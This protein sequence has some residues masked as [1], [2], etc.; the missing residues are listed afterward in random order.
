[1]LLMWLLQLRLW[2]DLQCII[3]SSNSCC[4]MWLLQLR[5]WLDLQCIILSSSRCCH[6]QFAPAYWRPGSSASLPG[7]RCCRAQGGVVQRRLHL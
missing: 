6:K 2:L 1:L 5:L 4:H 3:L 7:R